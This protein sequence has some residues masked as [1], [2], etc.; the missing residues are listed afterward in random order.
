MKKFALVVLVLALAFGLTSVADAVELS[1]QKYVIA[2]NASSGKTSF[3]STSLIRPGK[4]GILKVVVTATDARSDCFVG[5]YDCTTA[6]A[7]LVSVLEG[8]VEAKR[9]GGS[10]NLEY[11]RPLRIYNG[12]TI[13]QG[14]YTIVQLE[15]ERLN[16]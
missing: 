13:L 4:D 3:I 9:D 5:L 6:A 14:P 16:P 8:E 10:A 7:A 1:D 15:W 2:N 12:V 11:I